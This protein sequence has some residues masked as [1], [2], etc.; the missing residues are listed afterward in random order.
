MSGLEQLF[1][2]VERP[3]Q[4]SEPSGIDILLTHSYHLAYDQK[5]YERM[6]PY[7]PLATLYAASLLQANGIS[8]SVF[9]TMLRDP[10][11][12]E[13]ALK[14][15]R[16]KVVAIFEDSFNYLSKMCLSRM[17]DVAFRMADAAHRAGAL[18]IAHGSDA[19]DQ[20]DLF[21]LNNVDAVLIGEG[22]SALLASVK[23]FLAGNV[24]KGRV[25]SAPQRT[26]A[27]LPLP[28]L[29]L[30]DI[31]L[32]RSAW[33]QR[34]GYFSLNM[35]SSRGCPFRCNWCAKPIYGDHYKARTPES[36]AQEMLHLKRTY[37]PDRL[38]FADD[39][40]GLD[41][42]WV[43]KLADEVERLN[44]AIPFKIQA[45]ADLMTDEN[46]LNLRRAGCAEVWM[47]AESG[48][49][50][51][52]D[53]MEKGLRVEEVHA[54]RRTLGTHGIRA[55]YFLQFGY[56]GEGWEDIKKTVS[57]VRETRPDDIGVSVS[58]PL[59]NTRFYESVQQQ[60]GAKR[61]WRDS[62]DLSVMFRGAYSDNFY[63]AIR[64]ALH[65]E[66][67]SWPRPSRSAVTELRAKWKEIERLE[68][69]SRNKDATV[70]SHPAPAVEIGPNFSGSTFFPI[71]RLTV[72]EGEA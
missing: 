37:S 20:A 58:Y 10:E 49:Q 68:P 36:V 7:P 45:R 35:I 48:S 62:A 69:H 30:I 72:R 29:S 6:Q 67:S 17:R 13:A 19:T 9:D 11:E 51:I 21:L 27:E 53:A 71:D 52:L 65:L 55:C 59:P 44:A 18:V 38:W 5:Q 47:G 56:P 60:L 8:V 32:Y 1:K 33:K 34:H 16:P 66:V 2:H 42:R 40:F 12:F 28:D 64:D 4:S 50:K 31:D 15:Y 41:H 25:S 57:L 26:V 63:R 70:L 61:N 14:T 39:I 22:E 23:S 46:A 43:A 24:V 54:A 3:E